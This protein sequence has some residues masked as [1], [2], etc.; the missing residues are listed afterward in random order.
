M[1]TGMI[2]RIA[3]Q[4]IERRDDARLTTAWLSSGNKSSTVASG[5]TTHLTDSV[6]K[7]PLPVEAGTP[8]LVML[9]TGHEAVMATLL[10]QATAGARVYVIA[11]AT[12]GR[13]KLDPQL[14]ACPTVL[15]R[16][17]PEVPVATVI[18]SGNAALWM[19]ATSDGS[20][21]WRLQL[22]SV[23]TEAL[24]QLFLRLFWHEATEEAWTGGK[25]L[26]FR[27][28]LERPVDVPEPS[29]TAPIRLQGADAK[30]PV[31][32]GALVHL[33][34]GILPESVPQRLWFPASGSHH[35]ALALLLH[36]KAEVVWTQREL[37]DLVVKR[38]QAWALLPGTKTRLMIELN[39][40]QAA[41]A[42]RLLSAP[43][44][45]RFGL[46]VRLGDHS[47]DSARIWLEDAATAFPIEPEQTIDMPVVESEQ[48]RTTPEATPLTWPPAQPLAL[49]VRY[50][51]LAAPPCLPAGAEE[52][53]LLG[54]W[55]QV[56]DEWS[57]RRSKIREAL[58]ASE[59]H[60]GKLKSAFSRLVRTMLGFDQTGQ[61]L[62]RKLGL[63]DQQ[64]PSAA[65]PEKAHGILQQL[66]ELEDQ[67][68]KLQADLDETERK[69]QEEEE[70]AKQEQDWKR[71]IAE[72]S[73]K[74]PEQRKALSEREAQA[75]KLSQELAVVE[76]ELTSANKKDKA[77][78]QVQKKR[79]SDD[80]TRV[81]KDIKRLQDD[82][83][84]LE[85]Q[86]AELFEFKATPKSAQTSAKAGGRFVPQ[87]V[88]PQA[89]T[90]VPEE[91]L[92]VAGLLR[93]RLGKRYLAIANWEELAQGERDASRLKAQLVATEGL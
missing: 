44:S 29:R 28:A 15:I 39:A 88:P 61:E 38:G 91:A 78:L 46:D 63:L 54:K 93:R 27:P 87:A 51:W 2:R 31:D 7:G 24:R 9:R 41:D 23:Q 64:Q 86:A 36:Q 62:H 34:G 58:Q 40:V 80:M 10:A 35:Q 20:A 17:V 5:G 8:V 6:Y 77:D 75:Q 14:L 4:R 66:R 11:P 48:L 21:P 73:S 69:T 60:R 68:R 43:P 42:E 47:A 59:G 53:P 74:L 85:Q 45:W 90:G 72:A 25:Q 52:D 16:R 22:D 65:G 70:R 1:N 26:S 82:V 83:A 89:V 32:R 56:D 19:G 57:R 13:S 18:T 67:T 55:R 76:E 33:S 50:Q 37:P 92:P 71:R 49:T 12:F 30:L 81:K 84:L 79:A 3:R